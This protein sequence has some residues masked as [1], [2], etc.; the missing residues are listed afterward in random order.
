MFISCAARNSLTSPARAAEN[1]VFKAQGNCVLQHGL[2]RAAPA[3]TDRVS[4]LG[5][6]FA[7]RTS[8][9]GRQNR[10]GL[11]KPGGTR[12]ANIELRAI[13]SPNAP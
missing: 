7:M 6:Q 8:N 10:G 3:R 4:T 1:P 11:G 5:P 12:K 2:K 13:V 9:I